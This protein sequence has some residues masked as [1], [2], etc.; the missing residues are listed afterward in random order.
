MQFYDDNPLDW[1]EDEARERLTRLKTLHRLQ[2]FRDDIGAES[3]AGLWEA[4]ASVRQY[5]YTMAEIVAAVPPARF[6]VPLA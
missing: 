2:A 5:G 1:L 3:F 6:F 4:S